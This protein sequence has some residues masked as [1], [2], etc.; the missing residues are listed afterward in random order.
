MSCAGCGKPR[1]VKDTGPQRAIAFR[2]ESYAGGV[3]KSI[4]GCSPEDFS[5]LP[6]FPALTLGLRLEFSDGTS[7]VVS[8]QRWIYLVRD[9]EHWTIDDDADAN[10]ILTKYPKAIVKCGGTVVEPVIQEV[11]RRIQEPIE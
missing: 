7:R 2:A 9:G 5:A 3:L 10:L 1:E 6:D 11:N 8:G 4:I